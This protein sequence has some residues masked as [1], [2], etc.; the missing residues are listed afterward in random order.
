MYDYEL[1]NIIDTVTA[2]VYLV[3]SIAVLGAGC[4]LFWLVIKALHKYL[5]S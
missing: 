2:I 4:Y 5:A 1:K 3:L